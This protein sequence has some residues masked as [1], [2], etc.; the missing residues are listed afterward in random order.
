MRVR[1][2][3]TD[4]REETISVRPVGLVAAERHYKGTVP[5]FESTCY[6]AWYSLRPGIDFEEWLE[7]LDDVNAEEAE[8]GPPPEQPP[9]EQ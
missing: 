1:L 7:S 9:P 6:A 2:N 3:Y 4:G 5:P 8:P